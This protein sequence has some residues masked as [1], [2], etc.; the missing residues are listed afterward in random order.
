MRIALPMRRTAFFIAALAAALLLFFP[1]RLGIGWFAFDSIGLSAREARGSIWGGRLAETRFAG[2]P[3]GDVDARLNVLPLA[4][5]RAR[6]DLR[7]EGGMRAGV[8]VTRHVVGAE[9]ATARV[10]LGQA[11]SP[12]PLTALDLTDVSVR[13]REGVCERAGGMVRATLAA[14]FGGVDLSG[15]LTGTARCEG[16]ALLLPLASQS[17]LERLRVELRPDGAFRASLRVQP[18]DAAAGERLVAA[19]FAPGV[20]G[21]ALV[22]EGRL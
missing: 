5:G 21:Y 1:L 22:I 10:M 12:L 19:G 3:I 16:G 6:F 7:G 9:D 14:D 17:G 20:G 11:L 13:F 18:A 8:L 4:L 2:A 15:G